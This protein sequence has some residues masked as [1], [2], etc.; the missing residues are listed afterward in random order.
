MY[1]VQNILIDNEYVPL[2]FTTHGGE[3]L[4]VSAAPFLPSS[5]A[6]PTRD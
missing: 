2:Y 1:N 4:S 6:L 3:N 5:A